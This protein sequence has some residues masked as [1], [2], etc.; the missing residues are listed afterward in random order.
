MSNTPGPKDNFAEHVS[1]KL[2]IITPTPR[3][4]TEYGNI[5][6]HVVINTHPDYADDDFDEPISLEEHGSPKEPVITLE[7]AD[8]EK[9]GHA[10]LRAVAI[11]RKA[12]QAKEEP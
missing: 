1:E 2:L 7:P 11:R 4:N 12:V 9:I 5:R 3:D 8:A 10:L 6:W